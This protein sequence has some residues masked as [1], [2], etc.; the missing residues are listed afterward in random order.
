MHVLSASELNRLS[1][2]QKPLLL[3][4]FEANEQSRFDE[5]DSVI[6]VKF[7]ALSLVWTDWA[8]LNFNQWTKAKPFDTLDSIQS[9]FDV[10]CSTSF[11]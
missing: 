10:S 9:W 1:H 5:L 3:G 4:K 7:Y 6:L 8:H 2:F 11:S